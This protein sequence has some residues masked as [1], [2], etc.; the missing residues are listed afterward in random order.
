[1]AKKG[2]LN[3]KN[4]VE[5]GGSRFKEGIVRV[6]ESSFQVTKAEYKNAV[7]IVS[8]VWKVIRLDEDQQALCDD[9]GVPVTETLI[10]GI[11]GKSLAN[12][13]PGNASGPEDSEVE[14]LGV[15]VGISGPT[16]LVVNETW[17]PDKKSSCI[18]LMDSLRAV[19][20]KDEIIDRQWA[21]DYVGLVAFME[22]FHDAANPV[23]GSDGKERPIAY[24]VV[25]RMI[26]APYEKGKTTGLASAP[27][28]AK[29][30]DAEALLSPILTVLAKEM[31]GESLTRK[32][33]L[34]RVSAALTKSATRPEMIVSSQ[35]LLKDDVWLRRNAE[36]FNYEVSED[37]G[38]VSFGANIEY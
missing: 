32:A 17:N 4:A 20:F 22:T 27:K 34:Q 23:V 26:R 19:Q 11:G 13:H 29:N 37:A 14:D 3:P 21:P 10:F 6:E 31:A 8:L 24:K 35:V 18:K 12:A 1:M 36:T 9:D 30:K 5:S 25:K 33:L 7:P 16:L 28:G 38:I 15:A 2:L